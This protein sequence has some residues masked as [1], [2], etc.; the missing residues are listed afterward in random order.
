MHAGTPASQIRN[1]TPSASVHLSHQP[2]SF[3]RTET[4]FLSILYPLVLG[5]Q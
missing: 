5:T 3:L 2:G 4:T 1:L